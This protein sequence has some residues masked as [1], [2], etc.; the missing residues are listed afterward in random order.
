MCLPF[1]Y[2]MGVIS[3]VMNPSNSIF[4]AGDIYCFFLWRGEG[5]FTDKWKVGGHF[6][7]QA[8]RWWALNGLIA[9]KIE[10]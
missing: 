6:F 4:S 1:D 8:F 2:D 10:R 3:S 9:G 5:R 7:S